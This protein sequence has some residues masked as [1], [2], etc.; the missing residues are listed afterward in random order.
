MARVPEETNA[1]I[2]KQK[3][4]TELRNLALSYPTHSGL[5]FG[6]LYLYLSSLLQLEVFGKQLG[7]ENFPYL[8]DVWR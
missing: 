6:P 3:T 5:G 4:P 1:F 2:Q 8:K 7:A